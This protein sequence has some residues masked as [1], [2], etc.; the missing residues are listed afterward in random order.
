MVRGL[1]LVTPEETRPPTLVAALRAVFA[2]LPVRRRLQAGPLLLLMLMGAAAELFTLGALLPLLAAMADPE[3]SPIMLAI[4]PYVATLGIRT[5]QDLLYLF[6]VVFGAAA[7]LA[8]IVRL[9]LLWAS[10][11]FVYGIASELGVQI[12]A[13]T[14]AQPY[15]YHTRH[16]TS[17][18]IASVTKVETVANFVLM[19]LMTAAVALVISCFIIAGLILID[20]LVALVAGAGLVTIYLGVSLAT[21]GR[22]RRNSAIIAAAQTKRIRAMQEGL[23]GIRDVLIDRSQPVFVEAYSRAEDSFRIARTFNALLGSAPR[24]VVEAAGMVLIAALAITVFERPGGMAA[25]IPVLGA[26]AL[27]AQRLLPLVQQIYHG[28]AS[29]TGNQQLLVD[30]VTLLERPMPELAGAVEP[31]PFERV[32]TLDRVGYTYDEARLPALRGITMQIPRGARVGIAGKTGSGKSTLMDLLIGLLEPTEGEIRIDGVPLTAANRAAWQRNVAHVPQAIFLADAS[33][34]ENIA[35]GTPPDRID[36][37]RVRH[38]AEQAELSDVVNALPEGYDTRVGERGIQL[39]GGQRQRIGIARA[40]YKEARVLV[41]DEATSA[42]D[43]ETESAVMAAIERLDRNLTVIVIA[44]RLS[45]LEGCDLF[46][47]LEGRTPTTSEQIN[48]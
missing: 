44:H 28:W 10:Q 31:L 17:E 46:I 35:F 9:V 23:G 30:L 3:G 34:A 38:A 26:L 12:Y 33:I 11:R 8:A 20:P 39:S 48:S 29:S 25:G 27:G 4:R 45:T 13:G 19:P 43:N 5:P 37:A 6:A 1:A 24:Y 36:R 15:L 40:L 16:N 14:L 42:L 47:R 41:F 32:I 2:A 7:V 18:I 22:M 21:R